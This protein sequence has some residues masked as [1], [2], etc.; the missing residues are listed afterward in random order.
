MPLNRRPDRSS[1]HRLAVVATTILLAVTAS[2]SP[3]AETPPFQTPLPMCYAPP[4][5]ET[6][7]WP[8]AVSDSLGSTPGTA[9][10]FSAASLLAN[11]SGTSIALASVDQVTYGGGR[12]TGTGPFTYTPGA[13]L[14]GH[15]CLQL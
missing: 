8:V 9:V 5:P 11:D 6:D 12:I 13:A 7:G 15:R 14:P 10:T 3:Q 4:S 1:A 2:F